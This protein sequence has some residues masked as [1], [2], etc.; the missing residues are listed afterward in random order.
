[1]I[2]E[3]ASFFGLFASTAIL[4]YLLEPEVTAHREH[5]LHSL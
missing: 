5:Q 3:V 1:M 4:V 2:L